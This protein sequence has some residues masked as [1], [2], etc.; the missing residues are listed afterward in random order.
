MSFLI[1]DIEFLKGVGP[2]RGEALRAEL[3][4]KCPMD[5]LLQYPFRYIDKTKVQLINELKADGD[6]ALVKGKLI[7]L[8]K[9]KGKN[10]R[11]RLSALIKD[12]SGFL[13]LVWFQKIKMLEDILEEGK[14]Y[15]IYGKVNVYGGK[16]SIAHPEMEEFQN[17]VTLHQTFDPVYS[18]TEKLDGLGLDAKGRRKLVKNILEKVSPADFHENL[19]DEIVAKLKLPTRFETIHWVHFPKDEAQ[20]ML[21]HNRIKFEEFFFLQIQMLF[22]K[23][24]RKLTLKGEVFENVG[25]VFNTFYSKHL[26]FE[27]TN[28]QKRV[29]K[30]IR[31]DVGGGKQMN[32]LLQGDVG[33]GK[34]IVALLSMLLAIDNGFQTCL[35]APT[36]ILAQQHYATISNQLKEMD[37]KVAF[38][39]GSVKGKPRQV[40]LE[41]LAL[42]DIHILIGTHAV[43]EEKVVFKNLG[44]S[45]TDEQHRF[46]V[47]QRASMWGKTD[48]LPPHILV[49]TATPIPRT[50]AMTLYGDLDVSVIDELPPGRK[51]IVTVHRYESHRPRVYEFM[52]EQIANGNQI[53]VVYPLIE[54]SATL[55]LKDLQQGYERLLHN[56]PRP[57]YQ[58][59]VVHGRMKAKDKDFEMDRFVK[60]VT[61]IMVATTVIEVGVNVPNATTMI[62]ENCERFGLSQLHQLRGRVGRGADQSYCLLMSGDK[63]SNDARMRIKTMCATNNG[64]DIAEVDLELRGPG[65]IEGTRQS[66]V[67]SFKLLNL[68]KDQRIMTVAR[69]LAEQILED[70]PT[71]EHPKNIR[72]RNYL[73]ATQK[74]GGN[75]ALIS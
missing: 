17:D 49:M 31:S 44:L 54:E 36:E 56:F 16:A 71:L 64:F 24:T 48:H 26:P 9:I 27:L 47:A 12:S 69:H 3:G 55:D 62:I 32:R 41:Q 21:A 4:V 53:Y 19:P 63:L 18:S 67:T 5:L 66:G 6:I 43:F 58:I 34:T 29:I 51:D 75:W 37:L 42:G 1:Q 14:E 11:H 45:I 7:T 57:D 23:A 52:K 20:K 39:S 59:S 10:N 40:I 60:K 38:L 73:R 46:G 72:I 22:T 61:H 13:E 8:E 2:A 33:S 70:D 28:A 74:N 65:E 30:E 50:L 15:I 25:P 68:V 35:V